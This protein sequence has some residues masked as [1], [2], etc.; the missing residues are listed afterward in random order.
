MTPL[1]RESLLRKACRAVLTRAV[2]GRL[3]RG[4]TWGEALLGEYEVATGRWET[5]RWTAS[6]LRLA[7]R[8]RRRSARAAAA[9]PIR[10]AAR[11]LR[12][13]VTV[14]V[15]LVLAGV[16]VNWR[17]ADVLYVPSSGMSPT[18][19]PGDRV[20]VDKLAYTVER[21]DLVVL[22]PRVLGTSPTSDRLVRRVLGLPGDRLECRDGKVFRNGAAA[23][24][25][26]LD[27]GT[28]TDC[29]SVTVPPGS[30]FVLGDNRGSAI[31]SRQLGPIAAGQVVGK[32]LLRL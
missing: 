23:D 27:S 10:P 26:Y 32:V 31:D 20:L 5:L 8:E 4:S 29:A 6:G 24:E 19:N 22:S 1:D 25:A 2:R 12:R 13:T 17:V 21:G 14:A 15:V 3:D 28:R 18:L 9:T 11:W 30:Y 16:L 7:W